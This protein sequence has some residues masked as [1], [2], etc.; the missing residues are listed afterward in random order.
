MLCGI[1]RVIEEEGLDPVLEE[2][3]VADGAVVE[4]LA[5]SVGRFLVEVASLIFVS[6][7]SSRVDF[8][9]TLLLC[10][11]A[12]CCGGGV[13]SYLSCKDADVLRHA[14]QLAQAPQPSIRRTVDQVGFELEALRQLDHSLLRNHNLLL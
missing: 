2:V 12:D 4:A 9:N 13:W 5:E 11:K 1:R 7:K 6:M 10:P 14:L 8:E 3:P